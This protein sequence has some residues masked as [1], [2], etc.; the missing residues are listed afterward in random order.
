MS[1][2]F[3]LRCWCTPGLMCC[4]LL[5]VHAE[6]GASS[7]AE[8]ALFVGQPGGAGVVGGRDRPQP[9]SQLAAPRPVSQPA[10]QLLSVG[11]ARPGFVGRS[12][13]RQGLAQLSVPRTVGTAPCM[14]PALSA[15]SPVARC[16]VA[17]DRLAPSVEPQTQPYRPYQRS[18]AVAR[19]GLSVCV[20]VPC[21][22]MVSLQAVAC[23]GT[24]WQAGGVKWV[25]GVWEEGVWHSLVS[26][27]AP[28]VCQWW[29]LSVVGP[30][31]TAGLCACVRAACWLSVA[32]CSDLSAGCFTCSQWCVRCAGAAAAPG[33][34]QRVG[35]P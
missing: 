6:Y 27:C 20:C 30:L 17:P 16:V 19:Q 14:Q 32:V 15:S 3:V 10:S 35:R 28:C 12:P 25:V 34:M 23:C 21:G 9:R 5:Q 1:L 7:F 31:G 24:L 8:P 13:S 33:C 18:V 11:Q 4:V 29:V 22:L 26:I 2:S